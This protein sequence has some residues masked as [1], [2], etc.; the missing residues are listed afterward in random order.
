MKYVDL[1]KKYILYLSIEISIS[2]NNHKY[3]N[4]YILRFMHSI[5]FVK[6]D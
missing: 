3:K 2:D 1:K 4:N 5:I 6:L